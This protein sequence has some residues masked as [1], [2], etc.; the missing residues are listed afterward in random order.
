MDMHAKMHIFELITNVYP[1]LIFETLN[2]GKKGADYGT[3]GQKSCDSG[4]VNV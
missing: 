1:L 3:S 4:G 2:L